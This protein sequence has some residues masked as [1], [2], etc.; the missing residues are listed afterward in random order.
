MRRASESW[1]WLGRR[2]SADDR[3]RH[4]LS[5]RVQQ[6]DLS[7]LYELRHEKPAAETRRPIHLENSEDPLRIVQSRIEVHVL[8]GPQGL[9]WRRLQ[10]GDFRIGQPG[11][12]KVQFY[13]DPAL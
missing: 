10:E 9:C 7:L 4:V 11:K 3:R 12:R 13:G 5:L 8:A 1:G 2:S 6:P